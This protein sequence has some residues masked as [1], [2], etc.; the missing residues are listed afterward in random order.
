MKGLWILLLLCVLPIPSWGQGRDADGSFA[1]CIG[2]LK[3]GVEIVALGHELLGKTRTRAPSLS[4]DGIE[5]GLKAVK[6]SIAVYTE[7]LIY[8]LEQAAQG[9]ISLEQVKADFRTL[10]SD[11][12]KVQSKYRQALTKRR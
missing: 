11:L 2:E 3:R 12:R 5:N 8:A 10:C 6:D 1:L 9:K 4:T 7:E